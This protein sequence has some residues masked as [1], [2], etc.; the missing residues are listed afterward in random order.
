MNKI[1]LKTWIKKIYTDGGS[2]FMCSPFDL[3]NQFD[4]YIFHK[5]VTKEKVHDIIY[6]FTRHHKYP[7]YKTAFEAIH[8]AAYEMENWT[9]RII[10]NEIRYKI[11][12]IPKD[13]FVIFSILY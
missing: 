5:D 7:T 9:G 4:F 2:I 12:Q 3:G 10:I 1:N 6:T 11:K 8:M 13:L